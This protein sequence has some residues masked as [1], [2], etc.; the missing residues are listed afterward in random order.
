MPDR[1][2]PAPSSGAGFRVLGLWLRSIPE[3][4]FNTRSLHSSTVFWCGVQCLETVVE[5][6]FGTRPPPQ[7]FEAVGPFEENALIS[8][9]MNTIPHRELKVFHQK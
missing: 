3:H 9:M 8:S 5:E 7:G 4:N 2:T 1:R 6:D